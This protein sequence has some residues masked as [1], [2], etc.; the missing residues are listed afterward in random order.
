MAE[1]K[2]EKKKLVWPW[3]LLALGIIAVL[4]YFLVFYNYNEKMNEAPK[5]S[6]FKSVKENSSAVKTYVKIDEEPKISDLISVKENNSVVEAYVNFVQTNKDKM[7]LD[8][9]YTVEALLKL[10]EATDAI[11]GEVSYEVRADLDKVK[12]YSKMIAKDPFETS[13]AD[14]IKKADDILTEILQNI[15]KAKYPGLTDD[16]KELKSAS[17]AINPAIL[18]LEQKKEVKAFFSKAAQ[19]LQK[20]N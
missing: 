19:L 13:H 16:L 4:I 3:I 9:T 20:M 17:E 6:E 2:I 15:Q 5:T 14:N 11:A 12:V 1:I 8:H 10:I 7:S 18:T